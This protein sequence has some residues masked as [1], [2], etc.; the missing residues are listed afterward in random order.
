MIFY[1]SFL[2]F[3]LIYPL[4]T[5]HKFIKDIELCVAE[6]FVFK[7][8]FHNDRAIYFIRAV[9]PRMAHAAVFVLFTVFKRHEFCEHIAVFSG[10]LF[11]DLVFSV[12]DAD[13]F[14]ILITASSAA[15]AASAAVDTVRSLATQTP[16]GDWYSVAVCSDGSYGIEKGLI[17]SFPVRTTK[18][19]GWEIVQGLPVDAFSREKIDATV[20]ELKEERDAVSS[21]LKH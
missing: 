15:S 13:C 12:S 7:P 19:G 11:H 8:Y 14:E 3:K 18:D 17:C 10:K 16:E 1:T 4:P 5:I 2:L 20:N 9:A 21:L 6:F